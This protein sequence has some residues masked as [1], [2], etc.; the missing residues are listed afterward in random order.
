MTAIVDDVEKGL[1]LRKFGVPFWALSHIFGRDQMYWYR[2]EQALG[3]NSIVGTT[4]RNSDDIPLHL[5]SCV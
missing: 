1:F 4:I 5:R 3:Q 2:L